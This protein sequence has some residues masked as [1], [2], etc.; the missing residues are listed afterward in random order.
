[1]RIY[2][3]KTTLLLRRAKELIDTGMSV[4]DAFDR[5]RNEIEHKEEQ[6][7]N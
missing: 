7:N 5:V 4:S 2:D 6:H 1:L 3:E